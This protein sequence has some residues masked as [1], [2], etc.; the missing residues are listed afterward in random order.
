MKVATKDAETVT[1]SRQMNISLES[2]LLSMSKSEGLDVA[3]SDEGDSA[4]FQVTITNTG[5]TVLS[6]VIPTNWIVG[7]EAFDCDQ[8]VSAADSEFLPSSHPSGAPLVCEVTVPL[9]ASYVD[10]GGFNSTSE[11]GSCLEGLKCFGELYTRAFLRSMPLIRTESFIICCCWCD[12][13]WC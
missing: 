9:T 3:Y 10:A 7:S 12:N 6:S 1:V 2:T 8:D 5:N 4:I 11:V 13:D